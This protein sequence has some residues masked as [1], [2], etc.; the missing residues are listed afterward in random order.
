MIIR[1]DI[2]EILFLIIWHWIAMENCLHIKVYLIHHPLR[3]QLIQLKL[4]ILNTIQDFQEKH[5]KI[6]HHVFDGFHEWG[7]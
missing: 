6:S 5:V 2:S 3:L 7:L 1:L 4:H